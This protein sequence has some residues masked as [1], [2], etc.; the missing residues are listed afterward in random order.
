MLYNFGES[1]SISF[2]NLHYSQCY[3]F[4]HKLHTIQNTVS[5][6]PLYIRM[7]GELESGHFFIFYDIVLLKPPV[8]YK[9]M[10]NFQTSP[11]TPLR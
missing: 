3:L 10:K 7:L 1:V 4:T 9:F 5:F 8:L 6:H 11:L 2:A